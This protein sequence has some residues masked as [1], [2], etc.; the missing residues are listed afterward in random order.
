MQ[1]VTNCTVVL[2]ELTKP[3]GLQKMEIQAAKVA[4][5]KSQPAGINLSAMLELEAENE[6]I[7]PLEEVVPPLEEV[8]A[9]QGTLELLEPDSFVLP[10]QNHVRELAEARRLSQSPQ[11]PQINQSPRPTTS[12]AAQPK[13]KPRSSKP[14]RKSAVKKLAKTAARKGGEPGPRIPVGARVWAE[15]Q[16]LNGKQLLLLYYFCMQIFWK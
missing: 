12:S 16:T 5:L 14:K 9:E 7:P 4:R 13:A 6:E 2:R 11:A 1:R 3:D 10:Y 15:N 8:P